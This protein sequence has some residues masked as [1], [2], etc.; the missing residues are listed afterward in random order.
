MIY[1]CKPL[2]INIDKKQYIEIQKLFKR[3]FG[4]P[5]FVTIGI[6]VNDIFSR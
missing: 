6:C 2:S 5:N 3:E 1:R 4:N